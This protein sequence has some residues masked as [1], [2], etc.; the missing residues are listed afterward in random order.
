MKLIVGLLIS[1]ITSQAL[2]WSDDN[3]RGPARAGQL[4][5]VVD[6]DA[7]QRAVGQDDQGNNTIFI[8]LNGVGRKPYK[9][10]CDYVATAHITNGHSWGEE[11]DFLER[12][13]VRSYRDIRWTF[14]FY[15]EDNGPGYYIVK[16]KMKVRGSCLKVED[17]EDVTQVPNPHRICDP[18]NVAQNPHGCGQTCNGKV[19]QGQG[20]CNNDFQ[21]W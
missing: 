21:P 7:S 17:Q 13:V 15:P 20:K 12:K 1:F 18:A 11:L 16:N 9:R 5:D 4:R 6:R 3:D 14:G 8:K 10:I 2:A 19:N